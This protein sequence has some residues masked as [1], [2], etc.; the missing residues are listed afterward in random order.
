[1]VYTVVAAESTPSV[2]KGK[3]YS[4]VPIRHVQ[5]TQRYSSNNTLKAGRLCVPARL[6]TSQ[7][8]VMPRK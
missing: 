3:M 6:K 2:Q 4:Y 1:M 5:E 8:Y 7:Y